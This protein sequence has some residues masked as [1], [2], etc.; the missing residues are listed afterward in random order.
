MK[1]LSI[2]TSCDDTAITILEVKKNTYI[3]KKTIP[4]SFEVLANST[5]SQIKIHREFG[6]VFPMMAKREHIKNL[7]LLLEQVLEKITNYKLEI[8]RKKINKKKPVD[9]IAVTYGPGLEPSLWTGIVFAKELA[10]KWSIPIMPVNHMEGHIL[11]PFGKSKEK[12]IIPNI[13][14]PILSLLVSGGHTELIL[15]K[16]WMQY[17]IIGETLDDAAG[18]AYDKVARMMDL[19]YPGG[20]IISKLAEEARKKEKQSLRGVSQDDGPRG[21]APLA[22]GDS[23]PEKISFSFSLASK[24]KLPRPMIYSKNFDFSFSGLKTAVLYLIRDLKKENPNI[25]KDEKIKQAI[26]LEFENAVVETLIYKTKKAKEKYKIKTIIVAGGVSSNKHLQRE[27]K[28]AMGKDTEVLFP[29]KEL[30]GDNSIMIGIAGYLQFIKKN[31]KVP[32]IS[33][34]KAKG[35]LR[36]R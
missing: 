33:S 32:K 6:G 14:T 30:T 2:E 16:K 9:L 10:K 25:F 22:S 34:I 27:M 26:A 24:I 12:F 4:T 20:P 29:E 1:I 36:L 19:P 5:N 13:K 31:K 11:S 8:R 7:P 18:E 35:N 28:K 23:D 15:S 17:K 21:S 3:G